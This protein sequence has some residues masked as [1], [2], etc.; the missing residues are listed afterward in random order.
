MEEAAG[1]LGYYTSTF[2]A[3]VDD[4]A[5]DDDGDEDH[6]ACPSLFTK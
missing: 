4:D 6:Y 1:E 3:S 5:A 2:V